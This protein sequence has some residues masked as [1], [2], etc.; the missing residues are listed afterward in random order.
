MAQSPQDNA[1]S[2]QL[3]DLV[4]ELMG[5]CLD[6][7][8]ESAAPLV[9]A[10]VATPSGERETVAFEEDSEVECLDAARAWVSAQAAAAYY[11]VA[12]L[13]LVDLPKKDHEAHGPGA[14]ALL[15]EFGER[16][17]AT[18]WSAYLLLQGIG[19][20]VNLRWSDPAPAGETRLLLQ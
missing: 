17:A 15:V 7:L 18:G 1:V 10:T 11:A 3:D 5:E 12:F 6:T 2:P 19:E 8:A 9:V 16:G 14:D 4:C 20:G 13:G